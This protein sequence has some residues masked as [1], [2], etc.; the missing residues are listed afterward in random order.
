MPPVGFEPKISAGERPQ[1]YA[2]D[3]AATGTGIQNKWPSWNLENIAS[4]KTPQF[5]VTVGQVFNRQ[6]LGRKWKS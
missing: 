3:R 5:N 4:V 1:T 6:L 2:L